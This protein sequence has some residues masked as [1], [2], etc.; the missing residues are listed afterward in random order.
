MKDLVDAG[1]IRHW[2]VSNETTY[3]VCEIMRA[4]DEVGAPYP[5]TIQ[6]SFSLLHRAFET[7]LAE[8]CAP[9]HYNISLLP[10]SP[11]AGGTLS[12]K[13]LDGNA[14]ENSRFSLYPQFM[15]RFQVGLPSP[16]RSSQQSLL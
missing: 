14:P 5:I 3:G 8:A 12:G 1:K 13:Y 11:L 16:T 2:G 4:C 15:A 10:W 9:S 7:E 6:N